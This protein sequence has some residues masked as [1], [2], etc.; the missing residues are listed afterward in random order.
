MGVVGARVH[1][2]HHVRL[3]S[4]MEE[5]ELIGIYDINTGEAEKAAREFGTTAF[6]TLDELLDRVDCVTVAVPTTA[7]YEVVS[8]CFKRGKHV[9][10]KSL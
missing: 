10:L 2:L 1:G 5:A 8:I 4:Q 3:L 6:G 9:R 7:H